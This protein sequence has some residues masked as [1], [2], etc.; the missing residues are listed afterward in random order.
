MVVMVALVEEVEEISERRGNTCAGAAKGMTVLNAKALRKD[1]EATKRRAA[2]P[3]QSIVGRSIN[4][5]I[6]DAEKMGGIPWYS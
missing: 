5:F 3:I 2:D 6:S 1:A 4:K